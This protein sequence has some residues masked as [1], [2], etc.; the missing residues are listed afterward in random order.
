MR[1]RLDAML[2]A[3]AIV[4]PALD[5]LYQSLTD[6]QKERFNALAREEQPADG[7][8]RPQQPGPDVTQ[9]CGGNLAKTGN[10]PITRIA[11]ALAPPTSSAPR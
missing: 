11:Q 4:R 10:A 9:V 2:K 1:A 6:E 8:P 5:K 3:V 7:P